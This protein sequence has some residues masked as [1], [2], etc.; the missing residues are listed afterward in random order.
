M[1]KR[2][3]KRAFF[4]LL[5][6]NIAVMLTLLLLFMLPTS[7]NINEISTTK[8]NDD[9][10]LIISAKKEDLTTFIN[11]Y[12]RN[13]NDGNIAYGVYLKDEV[14]LVGSL[15]VF[16]ESIDM[17]MTFDAKALENGDLLLSQKGISIGN[18]H[19]PV[20]YVLNFIKRVYSFPDWV[21]IFPNEHMVYLHLT[22][23]E[24][25]NG[26]QIKAKQFDLSKDEITFSFK[27]P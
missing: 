8:Q 27:M 19:L 4:I 2:N 14:E 17:S 22:K 24:L 6:I 11:E 3:W 1:N 13:E 12:I 5:G 7:G 9:V 16:T 15:P 25:K 20:T 23:M 26:I 10:E 18:L 21:E